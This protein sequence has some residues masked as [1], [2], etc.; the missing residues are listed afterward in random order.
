MLLFLETKRIKMKKSLLILILFLAC[1]SY[2]L[3]DNSQNDNSN[4]GIQSG[5]Q[6]EEQYGEAEEQTWQ[7][8]EDETTYK[9]YGNDD[10]P[11][12]LND[13]NTDLYDQYN[14]G[15]DFDQSD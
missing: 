4:W 13:K 11:A 14:G 12:F 2:S 5:A 6:N 10:S 1:Q 15:D 3:A 7:N 8:E 9:K